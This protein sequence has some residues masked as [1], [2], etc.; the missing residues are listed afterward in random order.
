MENRIINDNVGMSTQNTS[1]RLHIPCIKTDADYRCAF[2]FTVD[3]HIGIG[4]PH[5]PTQ[6]DIYTNNNIME[7][8]LKL[9]KLSLCS[10]IENII[11]KI[12]DLEATEPHRKEIDKYR[13]IL[14]KTRE[15]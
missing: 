1:E 5:T 12:Q 15:V 13:D 9:L 14:Q 7:K 11:E 3:G 8:E 10:Y 6:L 2:A 4:T